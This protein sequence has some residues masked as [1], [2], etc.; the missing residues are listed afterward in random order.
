MTMIHQLLK[1]KGHDF[2]SVGPDESVYAAMKLM[3]AKHVGSLLVMDGEKLVGIITERH[4]ARDIVLKGRASPQTPVRDIMETE[5]VCVGPHETV[6]GALE[7]MTRERIRHLPVLNGGKIIGIVSI[8]D[9]VKNIIDDQSF[10]IDQLEGYIN[11][12]LRPH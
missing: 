1:T 10:T 5:V 7:V 8:G 6:D 11:G 4:Y 3:A 2:Y 9:L 12:E